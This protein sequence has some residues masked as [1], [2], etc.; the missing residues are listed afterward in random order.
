MLL[1]YTV[2]KGFAEDLSEG[3]FSFPIVH[4]VRTNTSNRQ[5]LSE[6]QLSAA[7]SLQ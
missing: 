4:A 6:S 3:K 2:N 1:Q 5:V 7:W